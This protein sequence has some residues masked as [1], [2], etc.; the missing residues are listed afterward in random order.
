MFVAF[1]ANAT[2]P[3]AAA[4]V[5]FG[6]NATIP[7][8]A[9][10]VAA[11]SMPVCNLMRTR[12]LPQQIDLSLELPKLVCECGDHRLG[13][14]EH[15]PSNLEALRALGARDGFTLHALEEP[16][17]AAAAAVGL[18]LS[19]IGG[20]NGGGIGVFLLRFLLR[21][22]LEVLHDRLLERFRPEVRHPDDLMEPI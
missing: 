16:L 1:G 21:F 2:I 15:L 14:L 12:L 7:V 17:D 20:G 5:A 3:V 6:A 22:L 8:A 10:L 9:D 13:L 4:L 19:V 11:V 18:R